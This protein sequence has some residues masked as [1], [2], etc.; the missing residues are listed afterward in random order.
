MGL[1]EENHRGEECFASLHIEGRCG[2]HGS[3]DLGCV[4]EAGH[5]VFS[6]VNL[7]LS[8]HPWLMGRRSLRASHT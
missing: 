3:V 1:E 7:L 6:S 5:A 2:Q 8:C 4:T